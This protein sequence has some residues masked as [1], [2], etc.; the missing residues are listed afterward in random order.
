LTSRRP[1]LLAS[2]GAIAQAQNHAFLFGDIQSTAIGAVNASQ[3]LIHARLGAT[4]F[5]GLTL[6][7][8]TGAD[9]A[10]S[11]NASLQE[12]ATTLTH[13]R[14][15]TQNAAATGAH[16]VRLALNAASN[17]QAVSGAVVNIVENQSL[18]VRTIVATAI[19][20]VNGGSVWAL[21]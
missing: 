4:D 21:D 2:V 16:T 17:A 8:L 15:I 6:A 19:G 9:I 18:H 7:D 10:Q 5:G 20:A 1:E 12:A 14:T 13:A 11:M 3:I